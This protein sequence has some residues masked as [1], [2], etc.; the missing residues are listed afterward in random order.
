[1][2]ISQNAREMTG[3]ITNLEHQTKG[4]K[5][6]AIKSNGKDNSTAK[7]QNRRTRENKEKTR[8]VQ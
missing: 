5:R 8:R 1:M 7:W 2:Y 4:I 3:E 6:K